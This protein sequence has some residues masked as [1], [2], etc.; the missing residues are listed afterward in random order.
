[1]IAKERSLLEAS[2]SKPERERIFAIVKYLKFFALCAALAAWFGIRD[3][4][5]RRMR[6]DLRM[7][8]VRE[9]ET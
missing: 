6:L 7:N 8:N 1:M 5:W 4:I 9:G 2:E 3:G